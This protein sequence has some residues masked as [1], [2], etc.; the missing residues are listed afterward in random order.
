MKDSSDAKKRIVAVNAFL[1]PTLE[2]AKFEE[3][4]MTQ[5]L[6]PF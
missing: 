5:A 1:V 6:T 2:T 3:F 4:I